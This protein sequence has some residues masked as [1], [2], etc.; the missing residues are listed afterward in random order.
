M[1][2]NLNNYNNDDL[3]EDLYNKINKNL[4]KKDKNS[5]IPNKLDDDNNAFVKFLGKKHKKGEMNLSDSESHYSD[6]LI[7]FH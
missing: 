3:H 6:S 1:R 2:E 5:F 4:K 7:G